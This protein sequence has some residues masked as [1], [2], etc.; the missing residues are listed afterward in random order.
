MADNFKPRKW[1]EITLDRVKAS[2]YNA[3]VQAPTAAGKTVF[4][5]MVAQILRIKK[6]GLRTVIIVPTINLLKQ[7]KKE[8]ANF[9]DIEQSEIG[10]FYGPKKD[11]SKNK[12]FMIYVINSA[13][14]NNN[15]HENHKINPFDF[16]IIDEVHHAGANTYKNLLKINFKYK[17]GISATPEREYDSEGTEKLIEFFGNKI[18]VDES[19]VER[20]S[21]I[22]NMVR[23]K[24]TEKERKQ[25]EN[26][27]KKIPRILG[28]IKNL[29]G[30]SPEDKN[31]F[32]KISKLM[33]SG[34][35]EAI[36]YQNIIRKMENLRFT[37]SNKLKAINNLAYRDLDKKTI[38]FCDRIKFVEEIYN[39]LK[40]NHPNKEIFIIHSGLKKSQ[41]RNQL[42]M[43]KKRENGI[44]VAAKIVDEGFDVPDASIGVLISFTK[45]KRQSIQRDGRILRFM[46]DKVAKKYVFV[47]KDVDEDSY[48]NI[49]KR[50]NKS[51][52]TIN[53]IWLDFDNNFKTSNEFKTSF[54]LTHINNLMKEGGLVSTNY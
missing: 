4:A 34:V 40:E 23:V 53:G 10:E 24:F 21:V 15:L 5:M 11:S 54:N 29:Y 16:V 36:I 45:S 50:T 8:L 51:I 2:N 20:S 9:F 28:I 38:I 1:Q 30:I 52:S 3:L 13:A 19:Y 42:E 37:A 22:F 32:K 43:F 27:K 25:Y 47:I 49:L 39:T 31:F 44:L 14:K 18:N 26:Y 6:P 41:Q 46:K 48:S 7:W 33:E 12:E 35:E 17:L